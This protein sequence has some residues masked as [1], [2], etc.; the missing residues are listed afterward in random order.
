MECALPKSDDQISDFQL[1]MGTESETICTILSS[2][3]LSNFSARLSENKFLLLTFFSIHNMAYTVCRFT[4][5]SH[6]TLQFI[7][8]R[9][10]AQKCING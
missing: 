2:I 8:S 9:D 1:D 10:K 3:F 6:F 5:K 7:G 4:P